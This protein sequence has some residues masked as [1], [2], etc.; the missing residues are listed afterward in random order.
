MSANKITKLVDVWLD[1]LSTGYISLMERIYLLNISLISSQFPLAK[2]FPTG[3]NV[4]RKN[5]NKYLVPHN[6]I[7][8]H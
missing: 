8:F 4:H 3:Q 5:R 7:A 2:L 6:S 1:L